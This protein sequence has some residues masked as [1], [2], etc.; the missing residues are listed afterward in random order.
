[1]P[2][3]AVKTEVIDYQQEINNSINEPI[4]ECNRRAAKNN[5]ECD[6]QQGN[7]VGSLGPRRSRME[8]RFQRKATLE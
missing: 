1:M 7:V 2:E 3:Q 8:Q 5:K 4:H 6:N